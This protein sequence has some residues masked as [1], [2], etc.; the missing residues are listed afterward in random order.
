MDSWKCPTCGFIATNGRHLSY[1][2]KGCQGLGGGHD[3]QAQGPSTF[4]NTYET[5]SRQ[6]ASADG[7]PESNDSQSEPEDVEEGSNDDEESMD[8]EDVVLL[9]QECQ[10]RYERYGSDLCTFDFAKFIVDEKLNK[11]ASSDLLR[12]LTKHGI[13]G[14]AGLHPNADTLFKILQILRDKN[15]LPFH[16]TELKSDLWPGTWTLFH[17]DPLDVI[18]YYSPLLPTHT[19]ICSPL[20]LPS[21]PH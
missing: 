20:T 8:E 3:Y 7:Q 2:I 18:R 6:T 5:S 12:L 4:N 13:N 15:P 19:P 21:A 14:G 9:L 1:H 10:R 11:R 16:R 17:R